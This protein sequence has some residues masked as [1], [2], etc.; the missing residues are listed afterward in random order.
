M[1]RPGRWI[2]SLSLFCSLGGAA[3]AGAGALPDRPGTTQRVLRAYRKSYA[4]LPAR[5]VDVRGKVNKVRGVVSELAY[6]GSD[7]SSSSLLEQ[8]AGAE[9]RDAL[10]QAYRAKTEVELLADAT[11]KLEQPGRLMRR[12]GAKVKVAVLDQAALDKKVAD[13]E[14]RLKAAEGQLRQ[15]DQALAALP[16]TLT[17]G[18]QLGAAYGNGTLRAKD[19]RVAFLAKARDLAKQ[20]ES[21][22]A[23]GLDRLERA[24]Q[25]RITQQ[26]TRD[27]AATLAHYETASPIE[28]HAEAMQ[29]IQDIRNA[30]ND[31][32][33]RAETVRSS[34]SASA[35]TSGVATSRAE[36]DLGH[37]RYG[38]QITIKSPFSRTTSSSSITQTSWSAIGEQVTAGSD[39]VL[40]LSDSRVPLHTD[41]STS[42]DGVRTLLPVEA[43]MVLEKVVRVSELHL[44]LGKRDPGLAAS[45]G[46]WITGSRFVVLEPEAVHDRYSRSGEMAPI[47]RIEW[48]R[49]G[50]LLGSRIKADLAALGGQSFL[51]PARAAAFRGEIEA[52]LTSDLK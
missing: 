11:A 3:H 29:L 21:S 36:L 52:G 45:V 20:L 6:S 23:S 44:A 12:L 18:L 24:L 25:A 16:R 46:A 1:M 26:L 48:T 8:M 42:V 30:V 9:S 31:A 49:G 32:T 47:E 28:L 37:D 34:G 40:R 38:H 7:F 33:P 13:Y 14:E 22:Y 15:L 43:R 10:V 5:Y 17:R 51:D 27:R 19:E 41:G 39:Y 4:G 2:L 50:V 35:S